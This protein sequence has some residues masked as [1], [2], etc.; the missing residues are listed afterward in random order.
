[1]RSRWCRLAV[2]A[3]EAFSPSGGSAGL[4]Q[5]CLLHPKAGFQS[6]ATG[7][8]TAGQD[9]LVHPAVQARCWSDCGATLEGPD[10][11]LLASGSGCGRSSP[12]LCSESGTAPS[13]HDAGAGA[14]PGS[15]GEQVPPGTQSTQ[16]GA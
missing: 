7:L 3:P 15:L 9:G 5:Q 4:R 12:I 6:H 13:R 8:A 1:M 10:L 11:E 16:R 14:G 2:R